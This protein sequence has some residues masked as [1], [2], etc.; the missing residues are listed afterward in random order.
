[1]LRF[2]QISIAIQ[3]SLRGRKK[4]EFIELCVTG[5]TWLCYPLYSSILYVIS[6]LGFRLFTEYLQYILGYI[7]FEMFILL[8]YV[9]HA[10]PISGSNTG[11]FFQVPICY[12]IYLDFRTKE[13]TTV[14]IVSLM[15]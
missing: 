6:T 10:K 1:M 5:T 9:A 14:S 15:C 13:D 11:F 2:N 4:G 8:F 3:S 7:L 12:V